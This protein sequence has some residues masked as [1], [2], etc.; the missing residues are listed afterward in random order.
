[1][2]GSLDR[3]R[4]WRL[5]AAAGALATVINLAIF[6]AARAAG[7][8]FTV[9]IYTG[10]VTPL[11]WAAVVTFTVVPFVLG[12]VLTTLVAGRAPGRL[13]AMQIVAV[14]VGVVSLQPPL[15]VAADGTT[16]ALLALMHLPPVVSF[17]LALQ[18]LRAA[19]TAPPVARE[20][21]SGQH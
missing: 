9:P 7:V 16:R 10:E 19:G 6:A 5:G 18:R 4:L 15:T 14:V 21:V 2:S 13:R 20:T 8:T 11:P 1:M 12:L 3:G 17:V